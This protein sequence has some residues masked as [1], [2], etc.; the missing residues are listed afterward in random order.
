MKNNQ[1]FSIIVILILFS[2]NAF[3]QDAIKKG[4]YNLSGSISYSNSKNTDPNGS[5]NQFSF[6]LSPG[7]SYF[8]IDNLL[9][10]GYISYFYNEDKYST[11]SFSSKSIHRQYGIGPGV[12]YYFPN[13]NFTPFVGVSASYTKVVN[14]SLEGNSFSF[15]TGI[16]YFLVKSVAIEPY[17][18]Y[19]IT[20]YQKD[21]DNK[22]FRF[23][24]RMNHY[25]L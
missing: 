1:I 12:R 13:T 18:E 4:V 24:I 15:V 2:S 20:S 9:I 6:S 8:I 23:G 5:S 3:S 25:I 21:N 19:S 7:I 10:G 11:Y 14:S 22:T 17:I 16:N